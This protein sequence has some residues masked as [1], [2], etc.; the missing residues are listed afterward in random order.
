M[1]QLPILWAAGL[2]DK[3]KKEKLRV[4]KPKSCHKQLPLNQEEPGCPQGV[5]REMPLLQTDPARR[6]GGMLLEKD[7]GNA[8]L[9]NSPV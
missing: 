5:P 8:S 6:A 4:P 1:L 3:I 7:S 2:Q 9:S